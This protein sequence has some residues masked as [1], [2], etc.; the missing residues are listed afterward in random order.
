M[1]KARGN[2]ASRT[3]RLKIIRT[4]VNSGLMGFSSDGDSQ[5][6]QEI[7]CPLQ[8]KEQ[9]SKGDNRLEG[10]ENRPP[11]A[12]RGALPVG[13]GI[14]SM[15]AA[16]PHQ[17]D[18]ERKEKKDVADDLDDRLPPGGEARVEKIHA[19]M[20]LVI[21][22]IGGAEH[23]INPVNHV[24][25]LEGPRRGLDQHVAHGDVIHDYRREHGDQQTRDL[26]RPN[27][28][29][30]DEAENFL[31]IALQNKKGGPSSHG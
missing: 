8:E 17:D 7:S 3:K 11:G 2:P 21:V 28:A 25:E 24:G 30:V 29:P 26:A 5:R 13:D 14:V 20:A 4:V 23:G 18:E 19:H 15:L 16:F 1:P 6:A 9:E 12:G 31:H 27:T 22:A 10:P